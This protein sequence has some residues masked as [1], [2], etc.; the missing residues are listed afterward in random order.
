MRIL[1]VAMPDS[2]HTARWISQIANQGWDIYLFPTYIGR[3]HPEISNIK[4]FGSLPTQK[5]K[6]GNGVHFVWWTIL[7]YWLD[8]FLARLAGVKSQK[9]A[10]RMLSVI[11]RWVQPDIVHSLEI[12][13]AGYLT[14]ATKEKY[15]EKFPAWI[16]T[17]WGSDIYLFGRLSEH[18]AKIRAVL[19]SCDYY[20]C[21][22]HRDMALAEN[23]GFSGTALPVLPNT[24]G[25]DVGKLA[26]LKSA[27]RPSDRRRILLKGYQHFAGRAL[28]GL[29][30]LR[31]CVEQLE[32]YTV[33]IFSASEAVCIAAELFQQDTEISV[34]IIPGISHEEM[35][36]MYG[37]SRIYIG[38]SISDAISTSL[39]EA[40]VMET[41]PIQSCTA[42]A[43]EWVE[44]DVSGFLVPPEDPFVIAKA[45]RRALMDDGLV[46]RAAEINARTVRE[47]L[48]NVII[49]PQVIE[50]YQQIFETSREQ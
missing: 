10:E 43:D 50:M 46:N 12:Q 2:V 14:L 31:L 1:F 8:Y 36:Q 44:D 7:F 9:F 42:C 30:A 24:G 4:V 28:V 37:N 6:L 35:L 11:I 33:A 40:M 21:E 34:E 22:C 47:R 39:L 5:R 17:N 32:G 29:Q 48:D 45:I 23:L 16:V 41:F 20:S 49:Q 13:H 38:L 18:K 25:F 19:M 3:V 15:L 27:G 26:T